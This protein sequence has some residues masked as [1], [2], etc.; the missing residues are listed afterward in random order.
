MIL[1]IVPVLAFFFFS[2]RRRH[3]RCSRDWSSDVC[4]T[5]D[6][7]RLEVRDRE[8]LV[9]I[10]YSGSGKSVALKHIV[11]LLHPD[12][13]DVIVDGRAVSTLDRPALD[14]KSVV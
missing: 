13:G 1:L 5:D 9:I 6:D 10:G 3:T 4:S 8:T 12:A 7:Q 2:S 11:G 14:R